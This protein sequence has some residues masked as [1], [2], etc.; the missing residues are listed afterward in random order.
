L[1]GGTSH[2]SYSLVEDEAAKAGFKL[3]AGEGNDPDTLGK[4][5]VYVYDTKQVREESL[6]ILIVLFYLLTYKRGLLFI[7][8]T[9]SPSTKVKS[10]INTT[11]TF[12]LRRMEKLTTNLPT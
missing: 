11:M 5:T 10:T 12:N 8:S 2:S 7:V 6:A 9:S 1:P 4:Q 3:V